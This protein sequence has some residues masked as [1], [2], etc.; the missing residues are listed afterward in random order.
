MQPSTTSSSLAEL[1]LTV[2]ATGASSPVVF[3]NYMPDG[4]SYAGPCAYTLAADGR[5]VTGVLRTGHMQAQLAMMVPQIASAKHLDSDSDRQRVFDALDDSF[6]DYLLNEP[7]YLDP[8]RVQM[9]R[10]A[11]GTE[12]ALLVGGESC[13]VNL[14]RWQA[15]GQL[16]AET[17]ELRSVEDHVQSRPA[18]A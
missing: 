10:F 12:G 15:D 9:L 16:H 5:T 6:R 14:L 1:G 3:D 11:D 4:P 7:T 18:L 8:M 2:E 17:L 13:F